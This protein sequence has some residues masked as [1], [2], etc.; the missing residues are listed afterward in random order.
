M[1]IVCIVEVPPA[2]GTDMRSQYARAADELN[3]GRPFTDPADW[4]GGLISH[5]AADGEDGGII[6]D[7][8]EDRA[9]MDAWLRRVA[10]LLEDAPNPRIRIMETINVVTGAPVRA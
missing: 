5:V 2:E 8:W 6:V 10:P 1:P 4:G 7:V 9:H 3:G